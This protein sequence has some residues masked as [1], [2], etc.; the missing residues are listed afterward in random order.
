[1]GKVTTCNFWH[2]VKKALQL[3]F[4]LIVGSLALEKLVSLSRGWSSSPLKRPMGGWGLQP[5]AKWVSYLENGCYGPHQAIRWLQPKLTSWQQPH[6]KL[7]A[8]A[9]QMNCS[10]YPDLQKQGDDICSLQSLN[11]DIIC[12]VTVDD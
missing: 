5:V 12:Y 1:M 8:R 4:A 7:W 10:W 6:E 2:Q 11:L 3:L 9:T